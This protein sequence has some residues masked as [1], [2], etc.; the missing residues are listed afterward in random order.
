MSDDDAEATPVVFEPP[1]NRL[2]FLPVTLLVSGVL[3]V[4]ATSVGGSVA[5]ADGALGAAIGVLGVA[6]SYLISSIAVAWAD[7]VSPKLVLTIGLATYLFKFS[8]LGMVLASIPHSGWAG[9]RPL[10]VG[11]IV[12]IVGWLTAQVWWTVRNGT[13]TIRLDR[14]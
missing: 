9:T 1:P 10:A 14:V 3:L 4:A 5:G 7:S 13:P 11:M 8:V 6:L 12:M 2:G